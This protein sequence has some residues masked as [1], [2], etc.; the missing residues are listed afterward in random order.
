MQEGKEVD[1]DRSRAAPLTASMYAAIVMVCA[2]GSL[3]LFIYWGPTEF[4]N[5]ILIVSLG[6]QDC[7]N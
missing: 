1:L 5:L 4:A 2:N 7:L 6:H 3:Y